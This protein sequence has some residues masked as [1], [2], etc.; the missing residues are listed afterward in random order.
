LART[1][2]ASIVGLGGQVVRV[3]DVG[4][5]ATANVVLLDHGANLRP[6]A[7]ARLIVAGAPIIAL[8]PQ[9][10]RDAIAYYRSAGVQHYVVKPVRRLSLAER[11]RLAVGRGSR[12]PPSDDD[13]ASAPS[14]AG[15]RVL[16]AED[17]PVNALIARTILTRAGATVHSVSDG[18]E[19]VAAAKAASYD[20][21]FLDLRMPRLDGK[22]AARRIR[23]LAVQGRRPR[24]IA[25]TAD[26]G[27]AERRAALD[28]GMDDFLAKPIDPARLA[29]VAARFTGVEKAGSLA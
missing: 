8:A 25:L 21:I 29:N 7:L 6:D 26:A 20:L 16:L 5:I 11:L 23:A 1:L 9:E 10:E 28:A 4:D 18:E 15:L 14:L 24:L 2:E 19:A 27:E 22:A 17:N 3:R 12:P 13:R